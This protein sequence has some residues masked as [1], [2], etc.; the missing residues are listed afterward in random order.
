MT[1]IIGTANL[2]YFLCVCSEHSARIS[3]LQIIIYHFNKLN[4]SSFIDYNIYKENNLFFVRTGV[5]VHFRMKIDCDYFGH[6][7][8]CWNQYNFLFLMMP[9]V[10]SGYW[11]DFSLTEFSASQRFLLIEISG[12]VR[13]IDLLVSNLFSLFFLHNNISSPSMRHA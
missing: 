6:A 11:F 5:V 1:W 7:S 12:I 10:C 8:D 4:I 3:S 13:A 9:A 2:W